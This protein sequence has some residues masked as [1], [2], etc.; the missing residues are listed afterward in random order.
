M[1]KRRMIAL[2]MAIGML[3][4]S[5]CGNQ[6]VQKEESVSKT[7]ETAKQEET[8]KSE[9]KEKSLQT[10]TL[11]PSSANLTS[12]I[13]S[14]IRGEFLAER[15]YQL[16]VWANSPE[17][18]NAIL[19]SGDLPDIMYVSQDNFEVM[20]EEGMLLNLDE[21]KDELPHVYALE[22]ADEAFGNVR[23]TLSAGTGGLYGLPN[24]IGESD[25]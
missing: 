23:E 20:V 6:E 17:K 5:A 21:Y 18:T 7:G 8:V 19:A 16:E 13:V 24:Y 1:L 25:K 14:G 10:I 9:E 12:G 4:L 2:C 3:T 22:Y 15:G 11:Y